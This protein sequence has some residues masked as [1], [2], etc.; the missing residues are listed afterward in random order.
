MKRIIAV[1]IALA[2]CAACALAE[3]HD[4]L[5]RVPDF[6]VRT[7]DGETFALS[8]LL[9]QK[10]VVLLNVFATWCPPC[11]AEF[12][13]LEAAFEAY[14]DRLGMV[15]VS[16]EPT[17]TDDVLDAFRKEY[18]LNFH[19]AKNADVDVQSFLSVPSIPVTL[20]IGK[21]GAVYY[22]QMGAFATDPQL[23]ETIEHVLSED[24]DGSR[25]TFY[26]VYC[27]DQNGN[28]VPG[29]TVAFCT[30]TQCATFTSDEGG[31]VFFNAAPDDYHLQLLK[32]PEGYELAEGYE[33]EA[34]VGSFA[35]IPLVY[36]GE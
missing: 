23:T 35:L 29:V 19:L 30:D 12:P 27:Y 5:T 2:L 18:G 20:L 10:D 13:L 3:S 9:E 28:D 8:E 1:L 14:G 25:F 22:S 16:I 32:L 36:T 15:A 34:V 31:M 17:D 7:I 24:Y 33:P 4:A 21:D 26:G 11:K 6:N